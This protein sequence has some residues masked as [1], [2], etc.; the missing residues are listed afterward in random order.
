[1]AQQSQD[2]S[3]T[4]LAQS[5]TKRDPV[6]PLARLIEEYVRDANSERMEC[7]PA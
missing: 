7:I 3:D 2:S 1:M 6:I 5:G 4:Q